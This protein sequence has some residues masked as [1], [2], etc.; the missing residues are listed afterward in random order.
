MRLD[1]INESSYLSIV[2]VKTQITTDRR[3]GRALETPAEK[4]DI[5]SY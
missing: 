4:L 2:E 3:V 1:T 5:E